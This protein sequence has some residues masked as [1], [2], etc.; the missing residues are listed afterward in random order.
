MGHALASGRNP[1]SSAKMSA[2]S[3]WL[4]TLRQGLTSP[5]KCLNGVV[6]KWS[7]GHTASK[8]LVVGNMLFKKDIE[9]LKRADFWQLLFWYLVFEVAL[10]LRLWTLLLYDL[11]WA[12]ST[13]D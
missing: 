12:Q 13:S 1:G 10:R 4:R 3:F 7:Y 2:G 6:V 8:A 5:Y 9:L 11:A